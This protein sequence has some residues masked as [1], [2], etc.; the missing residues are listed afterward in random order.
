MAATSRSTAFLR[1]VGIS[2]PSAG[3]KSAGALDFLRKRTLRILPGYLAMAVVCLLV[4]GPIGSVSGPVSFWRQQNWPEV[5][6]HA[7][8]LHNLELADLSYAGSINPF[9]V[10]GSTWTIRIEFECYLLTMLLGLAGL[11]RRRA[12]VFVLFAGAMLLHTASTLELSILRVFPHFMQG[13]LGAHPRMAAY[14]LAGTILALYRTE[15]EPRRTLVIASALALA[16]TAL[17]G[18]FQIVA[19]IAFT[20]LVFAFA[21]APR[22]DLHRFAR[23]GDLSYGIYLYGWPVQQVVIHSFAGNISPTLLTL[24]SFPGALVLAIL[25]WRFVEGPALAL[26]KARRSKQPVVEANPL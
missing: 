16:V 20:Y 9:T 10:N 3:K 1:S 2:S 15:W 13:P 4:I 17:A 22:P 14:F 7:F 23:R 6:R 26:K 25:S 11:L 8:T 19:P 24:V 12:V 5:V 18:G 21:F